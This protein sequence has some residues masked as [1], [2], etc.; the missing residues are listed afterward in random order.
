MR[1]AKRA[2]RREIASG[3]CAVI[4]RKAAELGAMG[5]WRRVPRRRNATPYMCGISRLR[6]LASGLA[7]AGSWCASGGWERGSGVDR[8]G[9]CNGVELPRLPYLARLHQAT[10][11]RVGGC[12]PSDIG[13]GAAGEPRS[14]ARRRSQ[15]RGTPVGHRRGGHMPDDGPPAVCMIPCRAKV[16]FLCRCSPCT[17]PSRCR[18]RLCSC[19]S[20][21]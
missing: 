16:S 7:R 20:R 15:N 21:R 4:G 18:R 17:F 5:K 14:L 8:V 1:E 13:P 2:S 10:I 19:R 11:G 6:R 9:D 3:D 12:S